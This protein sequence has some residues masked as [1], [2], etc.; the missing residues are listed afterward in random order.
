MNQ[1]SDDNQSLPRGPFPKEARDQESELDASA[2]ER[3]HLEE[4]LSQLSLSN[5][6]LKRKL[7]DLYTVFEIS[8]NFNAVLD[9]KMLL[10]TFIFTCLGQVGALKGAMFLKDDTEAKG[11]QMVKAKGSGG[12]PEKSAAFMESSRLCGYLTKL[13]R[14]VLITEVA[15]EICTF[16]ETQI[17]G[18]FAKGILVPLIHQTRLAGLFI[19][20]DKISDREFTPDDLEFLSSLGN[21]ISVAIENARLYEAE[22][23]AM[24]QLRSAQQQLVQTERVAALG[25]MSA[26]VAHEVNN[27][28]GIIKNYILLLK[29]AGGNVDEVH[30]YADIVS[31]EIDRIAAIVK[32]LK[33]TQQPERMEMTLLDLRELIE[34][35]IDLMSRQLQSAKVSLARECEPGDYLVKGNPDSLKQVFLNLIINAREAM[36]EGGQLKLCL[37]RNEDKVCLCF[38]DSGPGIAAE[39]IPRIFEPFYTTKGDRGSG[40]GL[41]VCYGIIKSHNGSITF[42]NLDPGGCFQI[43]LPAPG[44]TDADDHD[45]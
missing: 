25:E 33:N 41:S 40:L 30:N 21:Q 44:E 26:K 8:R 6:Q 24:Q 9:Y 15:P 5:R 36:P 34:E 32:Q 11:F 38:C 19:L 13:N 16:E 3:A 10:D 31:Q 12:M 29:R 23:S 43:D 28:L 42:K 20:A 2:D 18:H 37:G 7:F 27:P 4:K 39:V 22:R 14:P 1:S 45:S 35:T 17:L